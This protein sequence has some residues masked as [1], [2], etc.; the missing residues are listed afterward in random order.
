MALPLAAGR[1]PVDAVP[2][3][4]H[5]AAARTVTRALVPACLTLLALAVLEGVTTGDLFSLQLAA[6]TVL[7]VTVPGSFIATEAVA[8]F[9]MDGTLRRMERDLR[10]PDGDAHA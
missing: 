8:R 3:A 7:V 1:T 5:R 4:V 6:L 2:P 10:R 9:R